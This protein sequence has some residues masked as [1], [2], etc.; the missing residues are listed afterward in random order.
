[1]KKLL[2]VLMVLAVMLMSMPAFADNIDTFVDTLSGCNDSCPTL[3][4]NEIVKEFADTKLPFL[5]AK[6]NW[7]IGIKYTNSVR[8]LVEN[9]SLT[10]TNRIIF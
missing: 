7:Q 1:M 10:F 5:N 6:V 8:S 9:N 4:S 3:I 2:L